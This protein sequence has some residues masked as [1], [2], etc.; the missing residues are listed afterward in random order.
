[1]DSYIQAFLDYL[2]HQKHYSSLTIRAYQR[3]LTS[4][5][6]FLDGSGGAQLTDITHQDIRL[7]LSHLSQKGLKRSSISRHL[8]TIRSF[9]HF[10]VKQEFVTD[11]PSELVEYQSKKHRLPDFFYPEEI[12][13]IIQAAQASN[14][15]L[16]LRNL[17][18]I[19]LL[20]ATGMRVAE[21]CQ[22][23]LSQIDFQVQMI[24]VIGKGNKERIIP[25]GDQAIEALTTYLDTL[26][27]QLIM[28]RSDLSQETSKV[29]LSDKG[30]D[31]TG[32]HVRKILQDIVNEGALH[33]DI[34]PHKLRHTFATHLLNNGA[35]IRSVQELLGHSDLSSTQ[36]YTHV[37]KDKLRQTYLS[38]HP[39]A[40]RHSR[41]E[42]HS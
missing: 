34:H 20:Y 16:K 33:L 6:E 14:N 5:K 4:F 42:D 40:K 12:H 29:F 41:K 25:V 36:I 2:S 22:L 3:D 27:P 10:A 11:N 21:L 38:I 7:Y 15:P 8:S 13:A 37:T 35:D 24:R 28:N 39:R 17:A 31:L 30:R 32:D 23:S 1:M 9:F 19:E 26:R 18:I